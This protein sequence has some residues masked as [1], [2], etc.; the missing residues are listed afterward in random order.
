MGDGWTA[1]WARWWAEWSSYRPSDFLMFAPR[2]YWRSVELVNEGFWPLHLVVGTVVLAWLWRGGRWP[3][4]SA[5]VLASL[6]ALSGWAFLH[7]RLAPIFWVADAYAWA[8]AAQAVGLCVVGLAGEG[9][10]RTHRARSDGSGRRW[11]AVALALW[12]TLAQPLMTVLAGRPWTQSEW[13]G[14]APDSTAILALAWLL[15]LP[16]AGGWRGMLRRAAWLVPLVWC[17]VSAA[18]LATMGEWQ[19]LPMVVAPILALAAR[20]RR[21]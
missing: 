20:R 11:M 4:A 1:G 13:P 14:L 17:L 5:F 15:G 6:F 19:A 9:P 3:R 7:Q 16:A 18:T 8:F 12:S 10:A 2:T 21:A